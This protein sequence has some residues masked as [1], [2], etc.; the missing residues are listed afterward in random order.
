MIYVFLLFAALLVVAF[1]AAKKRRDKIGAIKA[2]LANDGFNTAD[3]LVLM[4]AIVAINTEAR[5]LAVADIGSGKVVRVPFDQVR[6]CEIL[7]DGEVIYKKSAGR[8]IGGALVGG[9]LLG[10]IGA[11]IGGL[12]GGSKGRE[13]INSATLKVYTN[14]IDNPAILISI[15]DKTIPAAQRK[16]F[17]D[18]AQR[19]ADKIAI[20]VDQNGR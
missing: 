10:G 8:T 3:S 18:A 7:K 11:I 5:Q 12:S 2:E 13:R 19:M 14:D 4:K 16:P 1:I 9:V 20:I 17:I 15:F 6:D